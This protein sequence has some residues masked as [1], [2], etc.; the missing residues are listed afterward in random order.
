MVALKTIDNVRQELEEAFSVLDRG[1]GK[2]SRSQLQA[3]CSAKDSPISLEEVNH[4]RAS[5][6]GTP[7]DAKS[8][9]KRQ[10]EFKPKGRSM[11]SKTSNFWLRQQQRTLTEIDI[12]EAFSFLKRSNFH[13]ILPLLCT[14]TV[15]KAQSIRAETVNAFIR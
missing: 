5:T 3:V 13:Q 11:T 8:D 6:T 15:T 7:R 9:T 4:Q 1:T 2:I 10:R 12:Y 14:D